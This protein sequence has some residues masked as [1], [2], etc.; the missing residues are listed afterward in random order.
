MNCSLITKEIKYSDSLVTVSVKLVDGKPMPVPVVH[1]KTSF[2]TC[3]PLQSILKTIL[4]FLACLFH[5]YCFS[6]LF[7]GLMGSAPSELILGIESWFCDVPLNN[8]FLGPFCLNFYSMFICH[9]S[10]LWV[11]LWSWYCE[12][13]LY[14]ALSEALT[15]PFCNPRPLLSTSRPWVMLLRCT[16]L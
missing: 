2:L 16:I 12:M 14:W 7:S 6:Y 1:A 5:C 15:L 3:T 4:S 9:F 10:G 11:L 8:I 13:S